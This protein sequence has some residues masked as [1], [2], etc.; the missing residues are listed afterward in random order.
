M[1]VPAKF[2]KESRS[3]NSYFYHNKIFIPYQLIPQNYSIFECTCKPWEA[4]PSYPD[5]LRNIYRYRSVVNLLNCAY[6]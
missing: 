1:A 6:I 4:S 2:L 5:S 3:Y